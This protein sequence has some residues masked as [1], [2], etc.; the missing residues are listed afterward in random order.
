MCAIPGRSAGCA[1]D[2]RAGAHKRRQI[3]AGWS[4]RRRQAEDRPNGRTGRGR[5]GLRN[6]PSGR[7]AA[8]DVAGVSLGD[9]MSCGEWDRELLTMLTVVLGVER[10]RSRGESAI[11]AVRTF[12]VVARS[13]RRAAVVGGAVGADIDDVVVQP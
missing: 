1:R 11:G 4:W 7:F 3:A 6:P 8:R 9:L 5:E 2:A 10:V 12:R 13:G